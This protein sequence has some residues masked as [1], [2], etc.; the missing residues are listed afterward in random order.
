MQTKTIR[1][2]ATLRSLAGMR[3]FT[4]SLRDDAVVRD[5]IDAIGEVSPHL[6]DRI[7]DEHGEF[8]RLANIFLDG[9]SV[10]VLDGLDTPI[11]PGT[12]R[13]AIFPPVGGG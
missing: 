8:T 1:L 13:I 2:F 3:E 12:D 5:L 9:R 7:I 4:V 11:P 10:L 6:K